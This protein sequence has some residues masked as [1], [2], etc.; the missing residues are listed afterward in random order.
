MKLFYQT[1]FQSYS[2]ADNGPVPVIIIPGLFGS[3]GNWRSFA[4]KL[5]EYRPVVVIDQ[6]N[7]GQSEHSA[8]NSYFDLANDLKLLLAE[9][10]L[11]KVTVCGH[12]MGG[13]TAMTFA[14]QF[15]EILDK[16]VVLD[17]APVEYAHSHAPI[18][19]GLMSVDLKQAL[20]R[21]DV[22]RQ[23]MQAIPD[24]STRMFIM[25]S[26]AKSVNGYFWRLNLKGLYDNLDLIGGFPVD[27]FQ[28][29][30]FCKPSL[31]IKGEDSDY[32]RAEEE[33]GIHERFLNARIASIEGAGHWVH[34]DRPEA[35]LKEVLSFI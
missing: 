29:D 18:L 28:F 34:I 5:S 10:G 3:S 11:D 20:N 16:L 13:K 21:A 6:R 2:P 1:Y 4:K 8:D 26:L 27:G 12:S 30:S 19:E 31:F 9:L 7:H 23:L 22:E 25:L 17:I 14:L 32:V 33:L 15:P 35:V 24:K